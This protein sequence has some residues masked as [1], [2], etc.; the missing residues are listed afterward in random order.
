[1]PHNTTPKK[2]ERHSHRDRRSLTWRPPAALL[3]SP[4]LPLRPPRRRQRRQPLQRQVTRTASIYSCTSGAISEGRYVFSA[5]PRTLPSLLSHV[6]YPL[7]HTH[8]HTPLLP[9]S[10]A[11]SLH[12]LFHPT[13]PSVMSMVGGLGA[14]KPA[15]SDAQAA[16]D[17]VRSPPS[18]APP[19]LALRRRRLR[20]DVGLCF[21]SPPPLDGKRKTRRRPFLVRRK[22]FY[23]LRCS[24]AVTSGSHTKN[25]ASVLCSPYTHTHTHSHTRTHPRSPMSATILRARFV[26]FCFFFLVSSVASLL[27]SP[28]LRLSTHRFVVLALRLRTANVLPGCL[29][30]PLSPQRT[31]THR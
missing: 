30:F 7:T 1:M 24:S 28:P 3:S 12:L 9:L 31:Q 23:R 16:A 18:A 5:H 2:K 4:P 11:F 20:R 13:A 8:A 26:F 25:R 27:L 14:A 17:A 10:R 22:N 19:S 15:D 21:A 6:S 29:I